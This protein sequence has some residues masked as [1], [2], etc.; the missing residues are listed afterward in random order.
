MPL[1]FVVGG[2]LLAALGSLFF[3][4][5]SYALRDFA[6][7]RLAERMERL[8]NAHLFDRIA[9]NAA[10]LIFITAV[11]R[12]FCNIMV[13]ITILHLFQET[14]FPLWI[15][16]LLAIAVSGTVTLIASVAIPNSLAKYAGE[17]CIAACASLL[18]MMRL[19]LLPVTK[20][21]HFSDEMIRRVAG[22]KETVQ[23]E[24]IQ[25]EILSAVE[26]GTKEG[27]VDEQERDM[28]ES[29][30][31][32]RDTTCGQIM[33]ARSEIKALELPATIEQV[34]QIIEE[35]G[36][37]RIPTY[38]G[39]LDHIAGI[40]YGRDLLQFIGQPP[41]G[42]DIRKAIH[43]AFFVPETKPLRDLLKDFRLQKVHIAIV[44]D[45]YGGTSGLVTIEDI[46]EELVGDIVD[47][48]EDAEPA[49][50][51]RITD[52]TWEADARLYI[53]ELNRVV[54]LSLPDDEGFDTLG[55][56]ISTTLGR[57]PPT[58]TTFDHG[59]VKYTI[60]DAEPQRVNRVKI[61][62]APAPAE[63]RIEDRG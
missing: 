35:S 31:E 20:I 23:P 58:G 34:K 15:R 42:F 30:I 57:I 4:T 22:A 9:D 11:G 46:L 53:D 12:L 47:E 39:T 52:H 8:G 59:D 37:S 63:A 41:D 62:L 33:T 6:R 61:E 54:G 44:L 26:E 19:A 28:I 10:D 18:Q 60:L 13:F 56:F 43:P 5:L 24:Q 27:I 7:P 29:V 51:K 49:M 14:Q 45:E 21:M 25:D 50:L 1:Y 17:T 3:S 38:E 48:H 2:A 36:H 32:F 55:G 40:L 16:Y